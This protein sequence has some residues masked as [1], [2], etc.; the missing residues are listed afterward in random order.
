MK[1]YINK[2]KFLIMKSK[3][4]R[5]KKKIQKKMNRTKKNKRIR[6]FLIK[7]KIKINKRIIKQLMS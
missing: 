4:Y 6:Q 2:I 7:L 3:K 1:S 5:L